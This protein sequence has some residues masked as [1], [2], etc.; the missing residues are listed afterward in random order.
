MPV[1]AY[2]SL[3]PS[4]FVCFVLTVR[5]L[6]LWT[7]ATETNSLQLLYNRLSALPPPAVQALRLHKHI[8]SYKALRPTG[9]DS[10]IQHHSIHQ[11]S[12]PHH[13]TDPT[14]LFWIHDDTSNL[15]VME[16]GASFTEILTRIDSGWQER[17]G[18]TVVLEG[19][20]FE[21]G[22]DWRIWCANLKQASRYRGVV[23]EVSQL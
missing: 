10:S 20:G 13:Q 16:M 19:R 5:R 21:W 1:T 12:L 15:N 6:F 3:Q 14:S 2:F 9:S 7:S 23:V 22:R 11:V 17:Q 4:F 18:T 8:L